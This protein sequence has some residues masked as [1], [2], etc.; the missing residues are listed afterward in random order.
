MGITD[1]KFGKH[2]FYTLAE[3]TKCG[4]QCSTSSLSGLNLSWALLVNKDLHKTV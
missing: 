4:F 1:D 2:N 3:L